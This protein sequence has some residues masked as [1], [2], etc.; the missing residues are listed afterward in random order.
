MSHSEIAPLPPQNKIRFL[1][2]IRSKVIFANLI[3]IVL[4]LAV[5]ITAAFQTKKVDYLFQMSV[6]STNSLISTTHL[7]GL[8]RGLVLEHYRH[9]L[10]KG[11]NEESMT[12]IESLR[13]AI[14]KQLLRFEELANAKLALSP[15]ASR[16]EKQGIHKDAVEMRNLVKAIDADLDSAM[17]AAARNDLE[18]AKTFLVI[19]ADEKFQE[20]FISKMVNVIEYERIKSEETSSELDASIKFI[21]SLIGIA[22]VAGSILS[23]FFLLGIFK[24]IGRRLSDLEKA[25]T[26]VASGN[27]DLNLSENENDELTT[28]ARSFNL[29]ATKLKL[30]QNEV[31]Q[32]Q[33]LLA[34]SAK[35]SSM[36]EMA[37]GIAHEINT[38]LAVIKMLAA[39]LKIAIESGFAD[40]DKI[41]ASTDKIDKSVDRISETLKT[42]KS[43]SKSS[44]DEAFEAHILSAIVNN[45][46][47]L[48]RE[49][50]NRY[51]VELIHNSLD[52]NISLVCQ[53][54]QITQV[55]FSLLDNAFDAAKS[56]DSKWVK[57]SAEQTEDEVKLNFT[58][59]GR[60][61]PES[62]RQ[63]LFQ[64]FFTTKDFGEG[65][66]LGLSISKSVIQS[67][68]GKLILDDNS[69][70]TKF[71]IVLPKVRLRTKAIPQSNVA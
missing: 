19:A 7:R 17:A 29:M 60:G 33:Q 57:I 4:L 50:F 39:Q 12:K 62:V 40:V 5:F 26:S 14:E 48:C 3:I 31:A 37:G 46:L 59:S 54:N 43:I 63:K 38:P 20:N 2:S 47:S 58:D 56:N 36:G 71:E 21:K 35:L 41:S 18:A 30:L 23:I 9:I 25:T 69:E 13:F 34:H 11:P 68:G 24:T 8:V 45:A 66:G 64:P 52:E 53:K 67:H 22:L 49:K 27:F 55:I 10:V 32:K 51:G 28:L 61:I 6:L 65:T 15:N 42:L 16:E 1:G 70:H 44:E